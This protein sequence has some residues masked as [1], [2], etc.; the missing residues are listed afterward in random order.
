MTTARDR[1]V[2]ISELANELLDDEGPI[3]AEELVRPYAGWAQRP[4]RLTR[5]RPARSVCPRVGARVSAVAIRPLD[6]D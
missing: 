4:G 3:T 6:F 5:S 2:E 1:H